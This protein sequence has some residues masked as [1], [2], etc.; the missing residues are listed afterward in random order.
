MTHDVDPDLNPEQSN[1]DPGNSD[2]DPPLDP[3]NSDLDPGTFYPELDPE[4]S[5][6]EQPDLQGTLNL[7]L[8]LIQR[9]LTSTL[10]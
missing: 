1:L 9:T 7:I 8:S 2:L 5:D 4:N 3:G 6:P 10:T